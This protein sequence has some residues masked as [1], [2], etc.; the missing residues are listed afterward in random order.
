MTLLDALWPWGALRRA[1][2]RIYVL[3]INN[4]GLNAMLEEQREAKDMEIRHYRGM[5]LR[6]RALFKHAHF[7]S[8]TTGRLMRK[9]VVPVGLKR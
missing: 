3:E 4:R 5:L 2:R 7:R 9:G 6:A 1:E 8:P